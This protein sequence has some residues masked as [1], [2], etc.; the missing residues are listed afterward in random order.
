L[1]QIAATCADVV[2][3]PACPACGA[4]T[5]MLDEAV[6]CAWHAVVPSQPVVPVAVL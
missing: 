1:S 4:A 6:I 2:T 5:D 3:K